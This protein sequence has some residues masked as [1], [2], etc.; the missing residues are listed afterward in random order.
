MESEL[1][2][3]QPAAPKGTPTRTPVRLPLQGW[4]LLTPAGPPSPLP[5]LH[6]TRVPDQFISMEEEVASPFRGCQPSLLN[7]GAHC[8]LR[9]P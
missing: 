3:N 8:A 1:A 5:W 7:L 9:H 6:V 4:S 2:S